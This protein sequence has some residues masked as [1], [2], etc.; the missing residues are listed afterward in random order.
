MKR[1]NNKFLDF[2]NT[3]GSD[4]PELMES[5]KNG[6]SVIFEANELDKRQKLI[7]GVWSRYNGFKDVNLATEYAHYLTGSSSPLKMEDVEELSTDKLSMAIQKGRK[8]ALH[9]SNQVKKDPKPIP[10]Y[11]YQEQEKE[12]REHD[13][14]WA[15]EKKTLQDVGMMD[16]DGN[17]LTPEEIEYNNR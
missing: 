10:K 5:I 13:R 12:K 1:N 2:L 4:E 7:Y 9:K 17:L 14:R 16:E 6:Y 15:E 3:I 8:L 11:I